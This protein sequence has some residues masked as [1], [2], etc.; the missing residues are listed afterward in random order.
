VVKRESFGSNLI[1]LRGITFLRG[2]KF[3]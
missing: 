1:S 2:S 3:M